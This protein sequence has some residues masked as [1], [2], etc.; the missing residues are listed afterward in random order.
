LGSPAVSLANRNSVTT[1]SPVLSWLFKLTFRDS[2]AQKK[3]LEE[4]RMSPIYSLVA[5]PSRLLNRT[6]PTTHLVDAAQP[7]RLLRRA[8][9]RLRVLAPSPPRPCASRCVHCLCGL[10][11]CHHVCPG[12]DSCGL[13]ARHRPPRI[14]RRCAGVDRG[15]RRA[16]RCTHARGRG[17][18]CFPS[19]GAR[20]FGHVALAP[21]DGGGERA[22]LWLLLPAGTLRFRACVAR[23][24]CAVLFSC[25]GTPS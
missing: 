14:Q 4:M 10:G 18:R 11:R 5:P 15:R 22:G 9:R 25:S 24:A 3:S 16:A 7:L 19:Q 17:P 6:E 13:R 21:R 2:T 1:H 8:A 20:S 12:P 23:A